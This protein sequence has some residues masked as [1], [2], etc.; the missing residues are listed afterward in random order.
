MFVKTYL[1]MAASLIYANTLYIYITLIDINVGNFSFKL[2]MFC[3]HQKQESTLLTV[4]QHK[5]IT[6]PDNKMTTFQ[7][8]FA[9]LFFSTIPYAYGDHISL[10]IK[11]KIKFIVLNGFQ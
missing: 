8:A 1:L 5:S 3:L 7:C 11:F 6:I 10:L 4:I 2:L 9:I